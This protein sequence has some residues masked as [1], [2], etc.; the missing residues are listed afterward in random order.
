MSHG[1]ILLGRQNPVLPLEL[2]SLLPIL[3]F[4]CFFHDI[5]TGINLGDLLRRFAGLLDFL[6]G[7]TPSIEIGRQGEANSIKSL[8]DP[9]PAF[10][11]FGPFSHVFLKSVRIRQAVFDDLTDLEKQLKKR[12]RNRL[13]LPNEAKIEFSFG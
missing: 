1:H 10:W 7:T 13:L 11:H 4:I 6:T 12:L 9:L 8:H 5:H 3:V 2:N